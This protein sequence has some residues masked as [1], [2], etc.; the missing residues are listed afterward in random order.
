MFS[1][2]QPNCITA[3]PRPE[4]ARWRIQNDEE[5]SRKRGGQ[6]EHNEREDEGGLVAA[7]ARQSQCPMEILDV[8]AETSVL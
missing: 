8:R 5:E 6:S 3:L 1:F 2:N 4:K 7:V